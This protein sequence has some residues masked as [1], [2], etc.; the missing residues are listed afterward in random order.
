MP[1]SLLAGLAA[2]LATLLPAAVAHAAPTL[3]FDQ[4]CY[5]PGDTMAFTGAGYT[6]GGA[7]SLLFNSLAT[8]EVGTFDTT[9][10]AAGAIAGRL[11]TPDPD[12]YLGE[13]DSAGE[14]GVAAND[15]T[16]V[17]GGAGPDQAVGFATIRL[18]RFEVRLEQPNGRAPRAAKRMRVEA[19]GFTT[20]RGQTLYAHYRR[21]R[22]T[23][24]TVK[25]GRLNGDCGDRTS[26]LKRA[27][28]KGLRPGRYELVFNTSR[29]NPQ[30]F[31]KQSRSLRLR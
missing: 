8:Q 6:S 1:R 4:P 12:D 31:P 11:E 2:V 24:K 30:A 13:N 15:M 16:L 7:V 19:V 9:A 28:P 17:Q 26:T 18:S 25:L 29:T 14:M 5:S 22:R 3:S 27:L 21:N 23:H 10:D 20:A